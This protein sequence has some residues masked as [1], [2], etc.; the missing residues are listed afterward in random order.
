MEAKEHGLFSNLIVALML[1]ECRMNLPKKSIFKTNKLFFL[2]RMVECTFEEKGTFID[3]YKIN[4]NILMKLSLLV[5]A[6][7]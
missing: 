3:T 6:E 4:V 1:S 7:Y 2:L 5:S